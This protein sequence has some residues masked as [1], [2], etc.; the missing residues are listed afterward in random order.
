MS[1]LVYDPATTQHGVAPVTPASED[2]PSTS[3][4]VSV[5]GDVE[6]A[7]A[8]ANHCPAGQAAV[9]L[10]VRLR[11]HIQTLAVP[12]DRYAGLLPESREKDIVMNA[13]RF[14]RK[15]AG[16]CGSDPAISLR[17]L[18]KSAAHLARYADLLR[19]APKPLPAP[20]CLGAPGPEALLLPDSGR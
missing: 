3:S 18:A 20:A 12:A 4:A 8:L 9:R 16:G 15:V 6:T 10:R 2:A 7:L 19:S 5:A 1:A 17:L 13:V 11:G 14:A